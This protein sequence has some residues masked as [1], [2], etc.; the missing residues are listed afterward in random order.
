MTKARLTNVDGLRGVAAMAVVIG[1]WAEQIAHRTPNEALGNTLKALFAVDFSSGRFGIVAFFCISGFVIP[2]SFRHDAAIPGRVRPLAGFIVSRFFRLYPAYWVS[3]IL[4]VLIFPLLNAPPL[5]VHQVAANATMLQQLLHQKDV[6]GVYWT[7][8]IELVFYGLC[9]LAFAAGQLHNAKYNF[10][11][12]TIFLVIA[13]AG[14]VYRWVHP[15]NDFPVGFPT[16]LAAM[17]FGTLARLYLLERNQDA[18]RY[19]KPAIVVLCVAVVAANTLAYYHA[20]NELVGWLASNTSYLAGIAIFL[21]CIHRKWF[22][23]PRLAWLGLISYSIYLIHPLFLQAA[24]WAWP[25][26]D[27]RVAVLVITPIYIGGSIAVAVLSQ[28]FIEAPSVR[29]GRVVDRALDRL[30][31]PKTIAV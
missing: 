17:H 14:G 1:H 31:K 11:M 15:A 16:Y 29:A 18:G 26:M 30:M 10:V 27:W 21:L 6:L 2:F 13:L 23:G 5:T 25:F 22:G 8:F 12:M 24:V 20:T 28:R 7:L 3:L 9:F 4:A 19:Y